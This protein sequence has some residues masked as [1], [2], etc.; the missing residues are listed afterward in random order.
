[1]ILAICRIVPAMTSPI[2]VDGQTRS[3]ASP[4][5]SATATANR[6]PMTTFVVET[7]TLQ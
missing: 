4:K 3:G 1:M 6:R 5:T 7:F 2:L